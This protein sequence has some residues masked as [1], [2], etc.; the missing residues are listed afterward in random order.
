MDL[1]LLLALLALL[2]LIGVVFSAMAVSGAI[3]R[4][5]AETTKDTLDTTRRIDDATRLP[6]DPDDAR[7]WLREFGGPASPATPADKR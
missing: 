7:D 4:K 3:A 2:V 5:E 6:S 1:I